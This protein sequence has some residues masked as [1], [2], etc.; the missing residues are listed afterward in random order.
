MTQVDST[1][2]P[3]NGDAAG[4]VPKLES[5]PL[6][7]DPIDQPVNGNEEVEGLDTDSADS[8]GDYP[9]DNLLIRN[10]VRTIHNVVQR[11]DQ[12]I[13]IMDPD[14][15]RD[16][17][18]SRDQQS[19]LI[20]SVIMR[21]PLPVF[22]LAED[23]EGKMVVV[24]GL[25]R[26]ST[27]Q[28]FLKGKLKLSL[29]NRKSLNDKR[30]ADLPT[31]LKNRVED[32]NLIFYLIDENVPQRAR[33]DIFD[34]VNSGEPLTRQQMRNCLFL[35]P[36]T[37]FLREESRTSVFTRATGDSLKPKLMRDREFVNR[38]CAFQ[39]L[40]LDDYNADMD[41]FLEDSL[42]H[43]NKM[44]SSDLSKLSTQFRRGLENNFLLFNKH[45]FRKHRPDQEKRNPINASL[46]DV[47]STGLSHYE[48]DHVMAHADSLRQTIY[49]LLADVKFDGAITLGT[50]S[51]KSV[52]Y[53]FQA[54]QRAIQE[55]LK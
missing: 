6:G 22:Y 8:W 35:G 54:A 49:D 51:T 44:L 39:L 17:I 24:D 45:A 4:R 53:R 46:W 42:R 7:S 18:W 16:F 36:A 11:I 38:F 29:P 31:K 14:F 10:E 33:L 5:D 40:D 52:T 9:L 23:K 2:L 28:R 20:E 15:E 21:I 48:K 34:R 25:Q 26:L 30:F 41:D 27:F 47:M 12:R 50:S 19:K 32:C 43:M 13:Y 1:T 37:A 3:H 55:V